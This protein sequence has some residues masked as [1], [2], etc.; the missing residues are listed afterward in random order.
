MRPSSPS[1]FPQANP[2]PSATVLPTSAHFYRHRPR[3]PSQPSRPLLPI[4]PLGLTNRNFLRQTRYRRPVCVQRPLRHS[5][6]HSLVLCYSSF[7]KPS[8]HFSLFTRSLARST[9][10]E[11][12]PISHQQLPPSLTNNNP[13]TPS[14]S[15][16]I[17]THD[18]QKAGPRSGYPHLAI[19]NPSRSAHP[20]PLPAPA[21]MSNCS[22]VNLHHS[23]PM[24]A[25][26]SAWVGNQHLGDG[27]DF[28]S[29]HAGL[30]G[31]AAPTYPLQPTSLSASSLSKTPSADFSSSIRHLTHSSPGPSSVH[32]GGPSIRSPISHTDPPLD[33][34]IPTRSFMS[35]LSS[36][37]LRNIYHPL[38]PN[39]H[40]GTSTSFGHGDRFVGQ[41]SQPRPTTG[42]PQLYDPNSA[43]SS[44]HPQAHHYGPRPPMFS[45]THSSQIY[46]TGSGQY[47]H[48]PGSLESHGQE[49]LYN[50]NILPGAPRKR[51]R[52]RF[53]EVERLYDCNYPG[54]TKAYGTLNHL[55]AH[56]AMQKH[57][58][59]RLPQE[60]KE[61]RKEWRARKKAEA[62]AR[63][64][65]LKQSANNNL[66]ASHEY[67]VLNGQDCFRR[68]KVGGGVSNDSSP[69][70]SS[71][72]GGFAH[73]TMRSPA[74][75]ESYSAP[76]Q[77][78][79]FVLN[80]TGDRH[81][82]DW[83]N[84]DHRLN[85]TAIDEQ[86]EYS[87]PTINRPLHLL[88]QLNFLNLSLSIL[89]PTISLALILVSC[90]ILIPLLLLIL[91]HILLNHSAAASIVDHS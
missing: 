1:L 53:D 41:P 12:R 3:L 68:H 45:T 64:T 91:T 66:S 18:L 61:I 57:G 13:Q 84:N 6:H 38:R 30:F 23:R 22:A 73:N 71:T 34:P 77:S 69:S 81:S 33:H 44:I 83:F 75:G 65:A 86:P 37:P 82:N 88:H 19:S 26:G 79:H 28:S 55:N 59:K 20:S 51:A 60:F 85:G 76:A 29:A 14:S 62:E 52:R 32:T 21:Q 74:V 89:L 4:T 72:S 15:H 50:F 42:Y 8:T 31:Q 16:A 24:T 70:G 49:R 11:L 46:A 17:T 47:S 80:T 35:T 58:A 43:Y 39:T 63:A 67:N 36:P 87:V 90:P 10:F 25:P 9:F 5:L 27:L 56:I 54:C 7:A 2:S 48:G 78:T 40:S